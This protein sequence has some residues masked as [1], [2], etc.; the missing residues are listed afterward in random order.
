[1]AGAFQ[2]FVPDDHK[3][4]TLACTTSSGA[5]QFQTAT[6]QTEAIQLFN[7][8]PDIVHVR[9]GATSPTASLPSGSTVGDMPIPVGGWVVIPAGDA[10]Y[11]AG[12]CPTSTATLYITPGRGS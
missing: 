2:N 8:G 7:A 11:V 1:M 3:T 6:G 4:V 5:R 10:Q 12:I 9:L